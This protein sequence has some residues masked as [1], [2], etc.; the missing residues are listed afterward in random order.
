M[1]EVVEPATAQVMETIAWTSVPP[2]GK[3]SFW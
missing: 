3:N 1:I 2:S